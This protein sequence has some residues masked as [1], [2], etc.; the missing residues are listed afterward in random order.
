MPRGVIS[1]VG[2]DQRN[3]AYRSGLGLRSLEGPFVLLPCPAGRVWLR[4]SL[5]KRGG[6]RFDPP[7]NERS[8]NPANLVSRLTQRHQAQVEFGDEIVR[9]HDRGR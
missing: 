7:R 8:F 4:G 3:P 6:D 1:A 5:E 2:R 9:G